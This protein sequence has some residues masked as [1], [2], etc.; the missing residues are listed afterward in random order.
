MRKKA[1][2]LPGLIDVEGLDDL[3]DLRAFDSRYTAPVHGYAS[4]D[5][6]WASNSCVHFLSAIRIPALIVNA[7]NDTFLGSECYPLEAVRPLDYVYMEVPKA[8]DTGISPKGG[9]AGWSSVL[10]SF[11]TKCLVTMAPTRKQCVTTHAPFGAQESV[12]AVILKMI[13]EPFGLC[14]ISQVKPIRSGIADCDCTSGAAYLD[15][16]EV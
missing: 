7:G 10:C 16:V 3:R 11:S 6:Y 13:V 9:A 8:E 5:D 14:I 12:E 15:A 1:A 2:A 4:A